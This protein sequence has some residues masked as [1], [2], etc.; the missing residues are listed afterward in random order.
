MGTYY[1]GLNLEA[2]NRF[3]RAKLNELSFLHSMREK[4]GTEPVSVLFIV[5]LYTHNILKFFLH[6]LNWMNEYVFLSA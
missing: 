6:I 1:T 3:L 4:E 5:L 2:L